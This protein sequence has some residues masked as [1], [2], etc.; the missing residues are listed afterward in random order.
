MERLGNLSD[1][2][3]R[4]VRARALDEPT[5]EGVGE[6]ARALPLVIDV[7]PGRRVR[8]GRRYRHDRRVRRRESRGTGHIDAVARESQEVLRSRGERSGSTTIDGPCR[9]LV[10]GGCGLTVAAV[11]L[12]SERVN[13]Q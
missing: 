4:V 13:G 1:L 2:A 6:R 8:R 3:E 11:S 12:T 9:L 5:I 7:A 10:A